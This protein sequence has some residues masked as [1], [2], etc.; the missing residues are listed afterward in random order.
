MQ[1]LENAFDDWSRV[2]KLTH[3]EDELFVST[4]YVTGNV[5]ESVLDNSPSQN[6]FL[7]TELKLQNVFTGSLDLRILENLLLKGVKIFHLRG[8]H[9]KVLVSSHGLVVGSQ[10]FTIAGSMNSEL[11]VVTSDRKA[12]TDT[13]DWV[14]KKIANGSPITDHVLRVFQNY[15][16]KVGGEDALTELLELFEDQ[17]K[18][19]D[20]WLQSA[21]A[22]RH[23]K[24]RKQ[25]DARQIG[26]AREVFQYEQLDEWGDS[27]YVTFRKPSSESDLNSFFDPSD[28]KTINLLHHQRYLL[29]N[30][31]NDALY[32]APANIQQ[33]GKFA[34]G[35]NLNWRDLRE[36]LDI[37]DDLKRIVESVSVDLLNP[38][39][40]SDHHNLSITVNLSSDNWD[41][42]VENRYFFDG[43]AITT[44][45]API[46]FKPEY[47][48]GGDRQ[49]VLEARES[50]VNF[51]PS[52]L[53]K[54]IFTPFQFENS[55]TGSA[56]HRLFS[57]DK[58]ML[59]LRSFVDPSGT[60]FYFYML[61]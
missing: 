25:S 17:D 49:A 29:I 28:R 4:P 9:S 7:I 40:T 1:I 50:W 38:M 3:P 2:A 30:K 53:F 41:A 31:T 52:Q 43:E 44:I 26:L 11:S 47:R 10:N 15:I 22:L 24:K 16:E 32:F 48:L 56:P 59:S 61:T 14:T 58:M 13:L 46:F 19:F 37:P 60:E 5:L 34:D 55:K 6:K 51:L 54:L 23:G 35:L 8:L 39:E 36:M 18:D 45:G 42:E 27:Q 20:R 33:I 57:E 12:I 21:F